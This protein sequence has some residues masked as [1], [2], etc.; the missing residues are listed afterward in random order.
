MKELA[1]GFG[2]FFGAILRY[3]V[4]RIIPYQDGFPFGTLIINL[5]GCF[6]LSWFF[7]MTTNRWK[8]NSNLKLAIGTGYTGAFT[9]FSTFSV[10]TLELIKNHEFILAFLYVLISVMGG[11]LFAILGAKLVQTDKKLKGEAK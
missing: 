3:L 9:T 4:G 11:I 7:T 10:E 5:L 6:F 8:I 1:V 2:G